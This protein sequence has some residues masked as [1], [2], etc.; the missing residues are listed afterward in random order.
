[1]ILHEAHCFANHKW[2]SSLDYE[3]PIEVASQATSQDQEVPS[4]DQQ[5]QIQD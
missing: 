4:Q 2:V 1:M 5:D 3:V